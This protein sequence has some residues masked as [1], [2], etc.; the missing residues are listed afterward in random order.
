MLQNINWNPYT[1]CTVFC[2]LLSLSIFH[3][4]RD[5]DRHVVLALGYQ[6]LYLW[7]FSG[8]FTVLLHGGPHRVLEKFKQDVIQVRGWVTQRERNLLARRVLYQ[9]LT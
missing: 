1:I 5:A 4:I 6:D 3:L 2:E 8:A 7:H 9:C